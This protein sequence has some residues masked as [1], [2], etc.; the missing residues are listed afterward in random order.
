MQENTNIF[1]KLNNHSLPVDNSYWAE[2]EERLRQKPRKM[3]WWWLCGASVA[4]ASIALLIT[5]NSGTQIEQISADKNSV[6]HCGLVPQSPDKCEEIPAKAGMTV[7]VENSQSPNKNEKVPA[8]AGMTNIVENLNGKSEQYQQKF[9]SPV[10]E[11]IAENM[12][13][14][15]TH[16]EHDTI[17]E[18]QEVAPV[19]YQN[20]IVTNHFPTINKEKIQD[21]N[22]WFIAAAMSTGAA[23]ISNTNA[24]NFSKEASIPNS[25]PNFSTDYIGGD[26]MIAEHYEPSIDDIFHQFSE[27]THLPPLSVGL[28]VRKKIAKHEALEIGVNYSFLQ[29]KFRDTAYQWQQRNATLKLHYI[30]ISLNAVKYVV[31][32]PQWHIYISL[33]GMMEKGLQLDYRQTTVTQNWYGGNKTFHNISLQ[34]KIPGVQWSLN[35]AFGVD[36]TIYRCIGLYFEPRIIY[37]FKNN[38]PVSVH[39][40]TPLSVGLNAGIR[41]E[42]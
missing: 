23:N 2:M 7:I 28:N 10:N 12:N 38:Q 3:F 5:L 39:T 14:Y 13:N 35:T 9:I 21:N 17:S 20:E 16:I 8:S 31:D 15:V 36:Y 32:K 42:F 18:K 4:A 26:R 22:S 33:G 1:E 41:F 25:A 27:V 30:G 6:R 40:E 37:Y 19:K 34:D 11:N 29:S 24:T